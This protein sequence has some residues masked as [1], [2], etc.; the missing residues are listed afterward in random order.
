MHIKVLTA[1][2]KM[3]VT[4]PCLFLFFLFFFAKLICCCSVFVQR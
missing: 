1:N 2:V 3:Y 4:L